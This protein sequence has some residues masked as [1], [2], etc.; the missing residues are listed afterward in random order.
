MTLEEV[1]ILSTRCI[2]PVLPLMDRRETCVG[3]WM[4]ATTALLAILC[5]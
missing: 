5:V 1:W 3:V 4:Q 2:G